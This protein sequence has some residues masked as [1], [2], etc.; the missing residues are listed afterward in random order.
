M[1]TLTEFIR[2][3]LICE[4]FS[5]KILQQY[6]EP[7]Q[8][9]YEYYPYA[10]QWSKITD[11]MLHEITN[12]EDARK[13]QRKQKDAFYILCVG[14][15]GYGDNAKEMVQLITWGS[16]IIASVYRGERGSSTKAYIDNIVFVKAYYVTDFDKLLRKDIRDQR[17][18][19]RKDATAL[20][21][22]WSVANENHERYK[23]ILAEKRTG[24]P[25]EVK[26]IMDETMNIYMDTFKNYI[27]K[28]TE[29]A[30]GDSPSCYSMRWNIKK[31]NDTVTDLVNAF[32][33]FKSSV[34]KGGWNAVYAKRH[35]D[36]VKDY[37]SKIA[38]ICTKLSQE[39]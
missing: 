19:M 39:Q 22:D 33:D 16:D 2:E 11:D 9:K 21:D 25:D 8:F 34:G 1:K 5:S 20:K 14:K 7:K 38:E 23:K 4:S 3:S 31:L 32:A 13:M 6:L 28:F 15:S 35:Y 26:K 36:D 10:L 30:E 27:Q 12:E 37:A 18:E 17:A 29:F 24:T